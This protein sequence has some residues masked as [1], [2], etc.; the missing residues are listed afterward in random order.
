MT[1]SMVGR[2]FSE[3]FKLKEHHRQYLRV[4]ALLAIS[5]HVFSPRFLR[6]T[7]Q[8]PTSFQTS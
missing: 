3:H 4:A 2:E 7:L 1:A 5:L 8:I 6:H